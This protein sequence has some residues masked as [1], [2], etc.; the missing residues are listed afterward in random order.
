LGPLS[1]LPGMSNGPFRVLITG[2]AGFIGQ[3]VAG[4]FVA[5]GAEVIALVHRTRPAGPQG[6]QL[7]HAALDDRNALVR[8]LA[9]L[10]P[11]DAIVNC[12]GRAT[13]VGGDELFRRAN[14]QGVLNLIE[15]LAPAGLPIGR[16]VQISTT[17]VYGLR[18]FR[19]ADEGTVLRDTVCNP[20]PK[21][22]I[23]AEKAI[24]RRLPPRRWVILRP[25]AV[26][27]PGD[28]SILPRVLNYLWQSSSLIHFGKWAGRNRWP[29][30]HVHNVARA[31][32]LAAR[33][34]ETLGQAYNVL[35]PDFT[36]VDE[37]YRLLIAAGLAGDPLSGPPPKTVALPFLVGWLIGHASSL[38]SLWLGRDRPLFEPSLY[39]LYTASCNLDFSSRK[40]QDLFARHG[41]RFV[42]RAAGLAMLVRGGVE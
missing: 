15:C 34:D 1:P 32:W 42:D 13:D 27:G 2:A 24:V 23:L 4:E 26:W 19:G 11:V 21:Y 30:A 14:Y 16:L 8:A 7:V 10:G 5:R 41:E 36:T 37:F 22:K 6:V 28:K 20:Y 9:P 38:L 12:A 40:L 3:A 18:D 17:D 33:C 35:D 25:A 39:G 29:L 31:A